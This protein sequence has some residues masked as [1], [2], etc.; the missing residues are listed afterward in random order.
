MENKIFIIPLL[1]ISTLLSACSV[2]SSDKY[3]VAQNTCPEIHETQRSSWV[4]TNQGFGAIRPPLKTINIGGVGTFLIYPVRTHGDIET[5]GPPLLPIIWVPKWMHLS[6]SDPL[7]TL[8]FV[9]VGEPK[10]VRIKSINNL[11]VEPN[12]ITQEHVVREHGSQT[13][14]EKETSF[15][16]PIPNGITKQGSFNVSISI[17]ENHFT[18]EFEN[19]RLINWFPLFVPL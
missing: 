10:D 13:R 15:F 19:D 8:H 18:L 5:F 6:P 1:I 14:V 3:F 9:F 12:I 7:N 11:P 4:T 17:R 16:L 2:L